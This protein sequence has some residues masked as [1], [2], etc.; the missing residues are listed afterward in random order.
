MP[1]QRRQTGLRG[2]V[3]DSDIRIGCRSRGQQ[4]TLDF[5]VLSFFVTLDLSMLQENVNDS[6]TN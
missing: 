1:L 5:D 6:T 2:Q 3:P 4:E